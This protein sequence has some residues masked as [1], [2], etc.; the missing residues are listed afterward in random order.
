MDSLSQINELADW[1]TRQPRLFVLTGAGCSTESG[2]PDYRDRHGQWKRKPPVTQQDFLGSAAVRQRYWARSMVGWRIIGQATPGPAHLALASL[3]QAGL[4]HH[5]VTQNVDGLHQRAG[6]RQV[7]ELHGSIGQV[8]CMACGAVQGRQQVQQQLEAA[9]QDWLHLE[10]L[11][12]PDGDADL[13]ALDFG[14]LRV[15][16]CPDCGGLIKPHVVFFGDSVPRPRLHQA[17]AAL[18]SA[19]AMLVLGSSL[20]VYSGYRFAVRAR[21]LGLPLAAINQG[22]TRADALFDLKLDL[23]V[24]AALSALAERLAR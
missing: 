2:I 24:G 6:S 12:A 15:P 9:N 1:M 21:E 8:V 17:M 7:I 20:T 23:P 4:V 5:L 3:E 16:D 18:A 14:R 19:Q 11:A 10:A 13:E 22:V